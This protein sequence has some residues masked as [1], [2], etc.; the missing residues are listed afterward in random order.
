MISEKNIKKALI[1]SDCRV[2]LCDFHREQAWHRWLV[3]TNNGMKDHKV[4]AT[5]LLRNIADSQ[6]EEELQKNVDKLKSSEIWNLNSSEK[7]WLP[8]DKVTFL[9]INIY[10]YLLVIYY[11]HFSHF[12]Q[13]I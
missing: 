10:Y 2:W 7:T 8:L 12:D 11:T 3:S 1:I 6:S 9:L 4:E 13:N 5:N